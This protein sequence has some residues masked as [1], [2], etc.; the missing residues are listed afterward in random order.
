M[1]IGDW[2]CG[3]KIEWESKAP[4]EMIRSYPGKDRL[5]CPREAGLTPRWKER[6]LRLGRTDRGNL[7]P[8]GTSSGQATS[9]RDKLLY[10]NILGG[11]FFMD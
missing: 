7:R 9:V 10:A 6:D 2:I 5:A 1:E 4:P 8:P 3:L 11:L